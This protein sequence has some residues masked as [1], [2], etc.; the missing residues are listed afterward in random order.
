MKKIIFSLALTLLCFNV[1]SQFPGDNDPT[2]NPTDIGFNNGAGPAGG[3]FATALQTDGKI[4]VGGYFAT[5][6]GFNKGCIARLE[7]NGVLDMSFTALTGTNTGIQTIVIQA[8]DKI[9]IGGNNP[10]SNPSSFKG[11]S[12][13]NTDGSTDGTF[14]NGVLNNGGTMY[15]MAIQP[16]GK[17]MAGGY[18]S[19]Y[20]GV[21]KNNILRLNTD[22]STDTTF[23]SGTGVDNAVNAVLIQADGKILIGGSFVTYNGITVNSI[24]RL[25]ADGTIDT[26]FNSGNGFNSAV[27]NMALQPDGKILI[28]GWFTDY[29][30]STVN[31]FVRLNADG[32]LD[33]S[34]APIVNSIESISV[35]QDGKIII[36]GNF[37]G[38]NGFSRNRLTRLN[39]NGTMDASF[40]IGS[41]A[42]QTVYSTLIQP[43][44]KIIIAG[45]LTTYNALIRNKITRLD[46]G[47]TL[48]PA[49]TG[50]TGT[51]NTVKKIVIQSSGN[52]LFGGKFTSINGV[53]KNYLG[54][55][56]PNGSFVSGYPSGV[57]P[58]GEVNTMSIQLS[59]DESVILG[60]NFYMLDNIAGNWLNGLVSTT[61]NFGN[62]IS[63]WL[64]SSGTGNYVCASAVQTSGN[65]IFGG[66]F[67]NYNGNATGNIAMAYYSGDIETTFTGNASA[68]DTV[69]AIA[70][71]GTKIIVGG[72]FTSFSGSPKN[73]ITRLNTNGTAD[74]TFT[75][76]LG[77]NNPVEAILVQPDGKILVGGSFTS[78]NGFSKKGIV[79]LNTDGTLDTTFLTGTGANNAVKA[80]AIQADGKILIGGNFTNYNGVSRNRLA[81]LNADGTLDTAFIVGAGA[82]GVINTI[83][84]ASN[85]RVLIGGDFTSYNGAGRNRIAQVYTCPTPSITNTTPASALSICNGATTKLTA[86]SLGTINWYSSSTGTVVLSV[87]GTYITPPLSTGSYTYYAEAASCSTVSARIPVVVSVNALSAPVITVNSGSVCPSSSFVMT[88]TG[89]TTYTYSSGTATV[90]PQSTSYYYITGKGSNGCTSVVTSTVTVYPRPLI[91]VNSGSVCSGSTFTIVPGGASTYTFSG[92]SAIVSP[93]VSSTYSVTGTSTLGCVSA[94]AAI[95]N[96]I[97]GAIPALT[98]NSGTICSGNSFTIN[99]TGAAGYI[100]PGGSP[101]VTPTTDSLFSVIGTNYNGCSSARTASVYVTSTPSITVNS[102]TIC[103]GNSFT[104]IPG[105]AATYSYSGGSATVS[106]ATTTSYTVTGITNGCTDTGISLVTVNASPS[107]TLSAPVLSGCEG[108]SFSI[109]ANTTPGSVTYLWN[110][111]AVTQSISVSPT[112]NTVYTATV[113][114]NAN[115][116]YTV[117]STLITVYPVPVLTVAG[118]GSICI[119]SGTGIGVTGALTYVWSNGFTTANIAVNPTV[120]TTYTVTGTNQYGCISTE[121]LSVFVD[122]TCADVW[123]GDANSDGTADNLDVLELGLHYTQTGAPRA[124]VS[125]S[126]QP[127]FANNW[128]GTITNGKNVSHS[129]CNG[130][131]TINDN[132]TLAIYN[133]YGLTHAFKPAQTNTVNPQLSIVPDQSMVVKGTWGS[134]SIYL[135]DATDVMNNINGIAFTVDFDHTLIEPN[136]IYIEYQNSFLDASQ[137]LYFR[138]L[139]FSNDKIYTATTHTIS[140]NVSGYGKIATLHY[141]VLSGLTTDQVLNIGLSQANQSDA[142]GIIT[143]VTTGTGTL[144]AIGASVGMQENAMGEP[145][146]INPNPA[147]D[148]LKVSFIKLL[149]NTRIELYNSIGALVFAEQATEKTHTIPTAGLS[150]GLYFIKVVENN[151]VV[152]VRK[153]V[154]Q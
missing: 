46:L 40:N 10:F 63:G 142:S 11:V 141:Q 65:I 39:A 116:C 103:A 33:S 3:I 18:F 144:M 96:V 138:K 78:Y 55:F 91:T 69:K 81:R 17:I 92:G 62:Q 2:F 28:S 128:T 130:D 140:N 94:S 139:D 7:A 133:N 4:I 104:I 129:D 124:G 102:G 82:N 37:I 75:V 9:V 41:G 152:I 143:P 23:S 99:A 113:T 107:L 121:T 1:F 95:S 15:A 12:R 123:P 71:Q 16:D 60:G 146:F 105:G 44:G 108:A 77:A 85:G 114:D 21:S 131:G 111:S 51:N 97:V 6:N 89:G 29:N 20:N 74:A 53:N 50:V 30:G 149:P 32:S 98:V 76:G 84:I 25:N 122:N 8:D 93:T 68:N 80:I 59:T 42:D 24:V 110:N 90:T 125:N 118:T 47:G 13:L 151:K 14:I 132:D 54:R 112:I 117:D 153:I 19:T 36:G 34:F 73:R 52:V 45:N 64:G 27:T 66:K 31:N 72:N 88:P 137:N 86:S 43:D 119:G 67:S 101:V 150:N 61:P 49:F 79:R 70:V 35:Q 38:V 83:A 126:W 147:H 106:P 100:Y 120:T 87:G 57:G 5:Y 148:V 109:S 134:A 26:S 56:N 58:N 127:Y 135:G 136:S 154:K 48:D 145:V 115:G 22:G